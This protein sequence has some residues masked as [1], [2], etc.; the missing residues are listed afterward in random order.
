M[1]GSKGHFSEAHT[2][3]L[4]VCF[5]QFSACSSSAWA[6][7]PSDAAGLVV[8]GKSCSKHWVRLGRQTSDQLL[9]DSAVPTHSVLVHRT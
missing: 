4:S 2:H 1:V 6:V 8:S 3:I 5:L 9:M 7:V